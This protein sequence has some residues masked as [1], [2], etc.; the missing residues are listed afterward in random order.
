MPGPSTHILVA[1]EVLKNLKKIKS[2]GY[3]YPG[4]GANAQTP[5]EISSL[6]E[7]HPNYYALG[8]IGPDLFYFLPDFRGNVLGLPM[9]DLIKVAEFLDD[10]YGKLDDW[11]LKYW[12]EYFGPINQNIDEAI[13]RMTGDLS[14]MVSDIMGSISSI[15]MQAIID[16]AAER[17]D[18]FGSFALGHN[19]GFDNKDFFW[20]DMLH[21]RK[22]SSFANNLWKLAEEKKLDGSDDANL[23]SDRLRA[24]ALGYM[25]HVA[26]DVTGH[27][28]VNSKTGGPYRLHWQRHHL[29]ETHIDGKTF[30]TKHG[31]DTDYNMYTKSAVYYRFAFDEN[32]G[33]AVERPA[34]LPGDD[35]IRGRYVRKRLLDLDSEMPDEL[36]D[37][38]FK[39]LDKT[40]DTLTQKDNHDINRNT[41][42]IIPSED[43]RPQPEDIQETYKL[44]FRYFKHSSLDGFAHEKPS[45]PDLFPNLDFPMLTDPAEDAPGASDDDDFSL[46]DLL[47]SIL[48]FIAWLA[49]VAIWLAT[50]LPAI[51]LDVATYLP[52]LIAYYCI[53]LP[54]YQMLK[55]ERM[56]LVM[57]GYLH[58]MTD[59]ID[60]ALIT[61]GQENHGAF[62]SLLAAVD[63]IMG[64][65]IHSEPIEYNVPDTE[66]PHTHP[67]RRI[68][69]DTFEFTEFN[70]PWD[71][72][73]TVAEL[74]KTFPGPFE[75]DVNADYIVTNAI[76]SD[77]KIIQKLAD[78]ASPVETVKI[79]FEDITSQKNL[80]DPTNFSSFLI[81]Q[82]ARGEDEDPDVPFTEWNMDSDR[83][84]AFKSWDWVRREDETKTDLDE[85]QY[86]KP[87]SELP[88]NSIEGIFDLSSAGSPNAIY[89]NNIKPLQLKYLSAEE[90]G[91]ELGG[92]AKEDEDLNDLC[93]K[94]KR[95]RG[96][97]RTHGK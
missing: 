43:G 64:F 77:M 70:H 17:K 15:L 76:P 96:P 13:S 47:L 89:Y 41:P 51:I 92:C 44:M 66:F 16:V 1:D 31:N 67:T 61:I 95:K 57:T 90:N 71:Y 59:E 53:E 35:T 19:V 22:T 97:D 60:N 39:A 87:C 62:L 56:I 78:A 11:I 45:P 68:D 32:T 10:L 50:I 85:H 54:L 24:Y 74:C 7:T 82:L 3:K 63:D 21:Y 26:T 9:A 29:V 6:A 83:G 30:D 94:S 75:R 8:A 2:W 55:A 12:E 38:L 34:N 73:E 20:S 46:L 84:Y 23:W 33:E 81:W 49:A 58:P 4:Y 27:A 69:S 18:W 86:G 42:D 72:P 5:S 52:R 93:Y 48:R 40:Y 88:Q 28:F 37:L 65:D 36:A 80:G 25:T 79:C 91:G 14:T